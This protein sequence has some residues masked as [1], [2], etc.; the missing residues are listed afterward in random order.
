MRF[1][2]IKVKDK[3][4]GKIHIVGAYTHDTLDINENG[5]VHYYNLQNGEGTAGDYEFVYNECKH[6]GVKSVEFVT[7]EELAEIA[8][9][10]DA[11]NVE[12]KNHM[13]ELTRKINSGEIVPLNKRPDWKPNYT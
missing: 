7:L 10:Q 4:N 6:T 8:K 9:L 11:S 3:T 12:H 1:P 2:V 13:E 5:Q